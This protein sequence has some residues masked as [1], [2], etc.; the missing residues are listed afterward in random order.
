MTPKAD[1]FNLQKNRRKGERCIPLSAKYMSVKAGVCFETRLTGGINAVPQIPVVA[2]KIV[3]VFAQ[4]QFR[5]YQ[6][7]LNPRLIP[8]FRGEYTF[9]LIFFRTVDILPT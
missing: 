9:F 6:H 8:R 5:E 3:Y 4:L 2:D 1:F 7:Y